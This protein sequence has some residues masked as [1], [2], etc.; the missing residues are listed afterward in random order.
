LNIYFTSSQ[1][2]DFHQ[3]EFA[4]PHQGAL[5]DPGV[6]GAKH[7]KSNSGDGPEINE[8]ALKKMGAL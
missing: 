6:I 7:L 3:H 8:P 4:T 1:F 2:F 5:I